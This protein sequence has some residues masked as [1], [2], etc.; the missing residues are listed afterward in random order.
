MNAK[1]K[2]ISIMTLSAVLSACSMIPDYQRPANPVMLENSDEVVNASLAADTGW[3]EFYQDE[4]LQQLIALSLENNRNLRATVLQVEQLR[5][6]YKIQRAE[7][8]PAVDGTA[9]ATRQRV[10]EGVSSGS[11]TIGG[12]GIYEEYQIGVGISAW[13]I[14]FLAGLTVCSKPLWNS[15]LPVKP[16]VEVFS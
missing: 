12:G 9:S 2:L 7:L 6:Q 4:Q 15:F 14:D 16:V 3:Q 5:A 13:E 1:L 10:P 8:L 11:Q